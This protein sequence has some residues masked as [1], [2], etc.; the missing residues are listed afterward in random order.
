[1][2]H[3]F[4]VSNFLFDTFSYVGAFFVYLEHIKMKKFIRGIIQRSVSKN[5]I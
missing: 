3:F 1:M 2:K 4:M 5:V